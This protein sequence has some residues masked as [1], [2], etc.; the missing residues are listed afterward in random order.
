[1]RKHIR[2]ILQAVLLVLIAHLFQGSVMRYFEIFDIAPNLY[3]VVIAIASVAY[4]RFFA[5]G[6]S[7]SI[8]ILTECTL[9]GLIGLNIVFYPALGF[10]S[11]ILFG[12]KTERRL[13]QEIAAGKKG[14]NLSP[15]LRTLL[16]A[17]FLIAVYELVNL[18]YVYL[19]VG[20]LPIRMIF[21]GLWSVGYT[22][23]LTGVVMVP[24][25]YAIGMYREFREKRKSKKKVSYEVGD[26][27]SAS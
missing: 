4:S 22:V 12:D 14:K 17:A 9:A 23:L 10:L 5:F 25:R 6:V 2:R 20:D 7:A 21:R 24:L 16:S 19:S 1:M 3:V 13:E 27:Q 26:T 18:V 11:S 8:G 15:H